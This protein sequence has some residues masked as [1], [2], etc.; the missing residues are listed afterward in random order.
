MKIANVIALVI[1][2]AFCGYLYCQNLELKKRNPEFFF[3]YHHG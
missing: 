3:Y 2:T 1:L